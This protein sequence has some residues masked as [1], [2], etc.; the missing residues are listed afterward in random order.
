MITIAM[1]LTAVNEAIK[2]N[3]EDSTIKLSTLKK[4]IEETE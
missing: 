4:L 3:G 2:V 1:L